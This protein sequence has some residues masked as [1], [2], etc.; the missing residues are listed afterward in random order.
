MHNL[1]RLRRILIPI[2]L[3]I[4]TTTAAVFAGADAP[5]FPDQRDSAAAAATWLLQEQQNEDGGF[6]IDFATQEPASNVPATLD[7]VLALSAA[8]YSADI[9]RLAAVQPQQH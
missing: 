3:V 8:G 1:N 7:A 9:F 6:G 5:P 2:L 4:L